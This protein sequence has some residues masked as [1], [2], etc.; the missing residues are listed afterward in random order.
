MFLA[1]ETATNICSVA[2]WDGENIHE[3]RTNSQGSHSE[4]LFLSIEELKKDHDFSISDLDAV[5]ISEGPGSYTGLRISASA[6]KGLLFQNDVPLYGIDTL[7]SFAMQAL[8]H[9]PSV[10]TIHSVIDARRKHLYY[11]QFR[12]QGDRLQA[13]YDTSATPIENIELF[14]GGDDV[15]IG[16]GLN[17]IDTKIL[18]DM[19]TYGEDEITARSLIYLYN[20]NAMRFIEKADPELFEPEYYTSPQMD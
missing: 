17:R 1:L 13:K 14:L 15:L 5:L 7:A 4:Q 10:K 18:N 3:Q 16:T 20:D 19:T 2:F 8:Q 9:N 6:V 11:Q 12:V